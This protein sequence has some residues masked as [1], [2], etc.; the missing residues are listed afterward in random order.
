VLEACRARD[1]EVS[2]R[3]LERWRPFLPTRKVEH[4]EG[5]RG[6]R[7]TNPAG[8]VEQ[9]IEISDALRSG[10]PLR[11]I[12]LVLFARKLPIRLEVLRSA[13]LDVF[14]DIV[15]EFEGFPTGSAAENPDPEDR[16]DAVAV[17]MAR[18]SNRNP[19]GRQW[20]ARARQVMRQRDTKAASAKAI[21]GSAL[22]AAFT[23]P[24]TG[25]LA[26]SEG[27]TE[28]LDVLGMN[29]G[30]DPQHL[31]AHLASLNI[32][33]IIEAIQTASLD[34][35]IDARDAFADMLKY[36]EVRRRVENRL[37]LA[38]QPLPGLG[39]FLSNDPVSQ[40][41]QIPGFLIVADDE[42]RNGIRF[43]LARWEAVDSLI[44]ALPEKF[45][46]PL[47]LN[48][49][50]DE[51]RQELAPIAAAW[52]QQHPEQARLLESQQE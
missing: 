35:W 33:A 5:V 50:P 41:M 43:E 51:I 47:L 7:T 6:S 40:A 14:S 24:M 49:I 18:Y 4:A 11:Q 38:E 25:K 1:I 19:L 3:Q 31:A 26:T 37:P 17:H 46:R 30:Q 36:T 27:I 22:S 15:R 13:Y 45:R 10:T 16:V 32:N 9:V 29:D 2:Q 34:E 8:Y 52:A 20:E 23:G 28:A 21:L 44:S 48:Q 42:W 12:P 39:D